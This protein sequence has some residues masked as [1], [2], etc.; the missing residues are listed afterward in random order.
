MSEIERSLRKQL[1]STL[2]YATPVAVPAATPVAQVI[3]KMQ[4]E[5]GGCALL[6]EGD[7]LVGIFTE[8]DVV[9]KI[10]G[11]EANLTCPVSQFMT[12]NPIWVTADDPISKA[13][14]QMHQGGFRYVPVLDREGSP[15][16]YVAHRDI[17]HYLVEHFSGHV[18]NLPPMQDQQSTAREGG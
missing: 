13:I 4:D 8:R 18:L 9:A 15:R 1:V 16:G 2:D 3:E 7:Q 11:D 12:P 14:F 10:L 5:R 17:I 6:T